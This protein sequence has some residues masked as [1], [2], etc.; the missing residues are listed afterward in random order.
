MKFD[1]KKI[2]I[3]NNP[4]CYLMKDMAGEV[5][6]IGKAKS[7]PQRVKSYW[8]KTPQDPKIPQLISRVASLEFV[9]T[10]NEVEALLLEARLIRQHKPR[11]NSMLKE[12]VPYMYIKITDEE[13][14]RLVSVRK[15]EGGGKYFGP[16]V[17]G[18]ARKVLL[19]TTA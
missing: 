14:P 18:R 17:S 10:R 7:L 1:Y 11:F 5:I 2:N 3:P 16:Y 13:F 19:L 15:I 4:G 8:Q 9:V 6:Y 12:N